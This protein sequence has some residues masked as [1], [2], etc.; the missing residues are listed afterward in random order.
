MEQTM[1]NKTP[2]QDHTE[3]QPSRDHGLV[4]TLWLLALLLAEVEFFLLAFAHMYRM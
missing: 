2:D 3:A 4:V 1:P